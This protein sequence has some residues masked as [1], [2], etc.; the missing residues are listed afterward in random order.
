MMRDPFWS[1]AWAA[2][3]PRLR[4]DDWLLLPPGGWPATNCRTSIYRDRIELGNAT[5]LFLHKGKLAGVKKSVLRQIM[6]AWQCVFANDV[7]VCFAKHHGSPAAVATEHLGT[8]RLHLRSRAVKRIRNT[9][10]F[11]HLPKAAG[12]SV[13]SFLSERVASCI[14]Y[15]TLESFLYN[16]PGRGEYDLVGGHVP[17]PLMAPYVGDDDHVACV[18]REPTARFRSA[19]LHSRRPGED[20]AT[21]SPV[22]RAMREQPLGS[23]LASRDGQMELRQQFLMLGH[24]LSG[25]Y[26]ER[27]D[28]AIYR[29]A[30]AWLR[31]PRSLFR[32]VERVD[33]LVVAMAGL[34]GITD[35][36]LDLLVRNVS[37]ASGTDVNLAEFNSQVAAIEAGNSLER[38]LY[39]MAGQEVSAALSAEKNSDP[40]R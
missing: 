15:D 38:S 27:M 5:V 8:L 31:D 29:R 28:E 11:V 17:L 37:A 10:F 13:W 34:L 24:D 21:F 18:I 23:F 7:F 1:A 12:T 6:L 39:E 3:E 32:T 14:Y 4:P 22:M 33:E 36:R 30:A 2:V 26:S 19:F 16:P 40:R 9:V 35:R 25:D 20:P